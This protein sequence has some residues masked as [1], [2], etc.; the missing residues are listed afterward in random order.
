MKMKK[1]TDGGIVYAVND[2]LFDTSFLESF[3]I[4]KVSWDLLCG[5]RGCEGSWKTDDN[6][7]LFSAVFSNVDHV[8]IRESSHK[9]HRWELRRGGKR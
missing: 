7:V 5:S 1:L 4:L 8:R 2:H 3:L 9:V 6:D